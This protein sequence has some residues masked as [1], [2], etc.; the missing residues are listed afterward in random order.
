MDE[1]KRY[2][3]VEVRCCGVVY[4]NPGVEHSSNEQRNETLEDENSI[5]DRR[6]L[7]D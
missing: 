3:F 4:L 7:Q 6:C 2:G 1:L 5:A